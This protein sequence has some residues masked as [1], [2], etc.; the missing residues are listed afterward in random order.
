M[1]ARSFALALA[2]ACVAPL[3]PAAN[4]QQ[5][6][7]PATPVQVARDLSYGSDPRQRVD[8]Y[9]P[10]HP[11]GPVLVMVHGGAWAIGDKASPAMIRPKV[12]YWTAR[13]YVV[14]SVNY[15]MLPAANPMVQAQDVARALAFVQKQAPAWGADPKRVALMGHSS[16]GHLVSLLNSAPSIAYAEG[17]KPWKATINLDGAALDVPQ[18]MQERHAP[19]YDRAFGSDPAFWASVSPYQ[20]VTPNK[21]LPPPMLMVCSRL[22]SNSCEQAAAFE[23]KISPMGHRLTIWSQALTHMEIDQQLGLPGPYTDSVARWISSIL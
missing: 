15:R 12:A 17:A 7:P 18:M 9:I 20:L 16:G 19:L 21:P 11:D 1:K 4:P 3:V 14:V 10:V 2:L 13:G 6:L 5:V 8:A 23:R 22:R